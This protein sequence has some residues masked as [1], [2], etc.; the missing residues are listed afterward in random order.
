MERKDKDVRR[1]V[2]CVQWDFTHT[3]KNLPHLA[4]GEV[5]NRL[6]SSRNFAHA[7]KRVAERLL[8]LAR[9]FSAGSAPAKSSASRSDG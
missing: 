4:P 7:V 2:G 8:K 1:T 3:A 9:H 6:E 5:A